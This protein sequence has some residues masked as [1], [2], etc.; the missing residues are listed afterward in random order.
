MKY[1]LILMIIVLLSINSYL[2]VRLDEECQ[3]CR[4]KDKE[5][6]DMLIK[7][8][9]YIKKDTTHQWCIRLQ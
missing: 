7:F 2:R 1:V 8:N 3:S 5:K 9:N 6:R 4:Q